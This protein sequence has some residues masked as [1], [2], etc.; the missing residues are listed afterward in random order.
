MRQRFA[1][2]LSLSLEMNEL[3]GFLVFGFWV[4]YTEI[5]PLTM[6]WLVTKFIG[7][8]G[9]FYL[10]THSIWFSGIIFSHSLLL[11]FI[12][13]SQKIDLFFRWCRQFSILRH[14]FHCRCVCMSVFTIVFLVNQK[15]ETP[16]T[17]I[18]K[19]CTRDRLLHVKWRLVPELQWNM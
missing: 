3:F 16:K 8:T 19:M 10:V 17:E 11:Y 1:A 9:G 14:S 6:A 4:P 18:G 7:I 2:A 15:F 13:C 5:K 12:Y